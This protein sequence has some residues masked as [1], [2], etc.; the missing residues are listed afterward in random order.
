M[1]IKRIT[2]SVIIVKINAK[3]VKLVKTNI[4]SL[5]NHDIVYHGTCPEID[6]SENY[7]GETARRI[8]ERVKV[9]TGKDVHS[10]LFKHAVESGH[11]IVDMMLPAIVVLEKGIHTTPENVKLLRP[12]K[13]LSQ[14]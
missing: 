7:V 6:C 8:S 4:S 3:D 1:I 13:K 12:L 2:R 14:H 5:H 11:A 9:H 10:D